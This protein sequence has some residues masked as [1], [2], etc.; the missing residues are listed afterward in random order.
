MAITANPPFPGLVAL[1]PAPDPQSYEADLLARVTRAVLDHRQAPCRIKALWEYPSGYSNI[2]TYLVEIEGVRGGT[3]C[4]I[5]VKWGPHLTY[6]KRSVGP[7]EEVSEA[8]RDYA[9]AVHGKIIDPTGEQMA[10]FLAWYL[11]ELSQWECSLMRAEEEDMLDPSLLSVYEIMEAVFARLPQAEQHA[12]RRMRCRRYVLNAHGRARD[13]YMPLADYIRGLPFRAEI[14]RIEAAHGEAR[15]RLFEWWKGS[16]YVDYNLPAPDPHTPHDTLQV[17]ASFPHESKVYRRVEVW[18]QI[19]CCR[20]Q[21]PVYTPGDPDAT[22]PGVRLIHRASGKEVE[23][24]LLPAP[25]PARGTLCECVR[26]CARR[27]S[28]L[29][30][31]DRCADRSLTSQQ[32][33]GARLSLEAILRETVLGGHHICGATEQEA[34]P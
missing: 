7:E 4:D 28:R 6:W 34:E 27:I 2:G 5:V 12:C 30:D 19:A 3:E 33:R 15:T 32:F 24:F 29:V 17:L 8:L 9:E 18:G 16:R 10:A 13:H 14:E 21:L 23:H 26:E 1:E 22:R 20:E 25:V 11:D 31:L